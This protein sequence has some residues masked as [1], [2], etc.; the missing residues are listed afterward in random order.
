MKLQMQ[1]VTLETFF[2]LGIG[3]VF[4]SLPKCPEVDFNYQKRIQYE[5]GS[6]SLVNQTIQF[7]LTFSNNTAIMPQLCVNEKDGFQVRRRCLAN[8][9][10]ETL[11]N[12]I[13]RPT[14]KLSEDL[15]NMDLELNPI[16]SDRSGGMNYDIAIHNITDMI[17]GLMGPLED[18]EVISLANII[19]VV[20]ES[21]DV[22]LDVST[23]I[24]SMYNHLMDKSSEILQL[25]IL[26]NATRNLLQNFERFTNKLEPP[27][28]DGTA[29]NYTIRVLD[30]R[31]DAG[32][33][34][35]I[36]EEISLLHL[37]PECKNYTGVAIYNGQG[38]DRRHCQHHGYWYRLLRP[39][40][41]LLEL[42]QEKNL[43]AA[44]YLT[45]D[46]WRALKES[47]AKYLVFKIYTNNAF[48]FA[49][50]TQEKRKVTPISNVLSLNVIGVDGNSNILQLELII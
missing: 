15:F 37:N 48:F 36:G 43:I 11:D 40:Q 31:K 10:W 39:D 47:K 5:N 44:T 21:S 29:S 23:D 8:N 3:Y 1:W 13:C 26:Q 9:T 7:P 25:A 50:S 17:M 18:H 38:P 19:K 46:L 35:L 6:V 2:V 33:L 4:G 24:I 41:N 14:R 49:D 34:L 28:C 20:T 45:N 16:I 22:N 32:L 12:I 30:M 42:K 27:H